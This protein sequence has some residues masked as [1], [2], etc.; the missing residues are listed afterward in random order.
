M[1]A[2]AVLRMFYDLLSCFFQTPNV[3]SSSPNWLVGCLMCVV[4]VSSFIID[5]V[6]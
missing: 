2:F 3:F 4:L 6:L 1:V 5:D